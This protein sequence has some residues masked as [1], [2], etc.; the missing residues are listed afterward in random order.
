LPDTGTFRGP[1][2]DIWPDST[3]RTGYHA[4]FIAREPARTLPPAP[5]VRT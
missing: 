3:W 2:D 1:C 4:C 5:A